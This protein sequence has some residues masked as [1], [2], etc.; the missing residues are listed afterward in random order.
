MRDTETA[1]ALQAWFEADPASASAWI[2]NSGL[3]DEVKA[4]LLP[5]H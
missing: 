4:R 3:P 1:A 2:A 5:A